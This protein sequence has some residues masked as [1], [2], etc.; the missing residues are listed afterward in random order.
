MG[1][2]LWLPPGQA[3]LMA[4]D[5]A[6][7]AAA[8]LQCRPLAQTLHDTAAWLAT[9]PPAPAAGVMARPAVGLPADE[10]ARLRALS[11]GH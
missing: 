3:Q 9:D 8:G 2:P 11:A 6:R 7:A 10:E 1:L 4:V 5:I